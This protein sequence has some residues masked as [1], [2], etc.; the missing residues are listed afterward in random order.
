MKVFL[1]LWGDPKFY[2]TLIFLAQYLSKKGLKIFIISKNTK[3]DKNIIKKVDFGKNTKIIQSP[4]LFSGYSNIIDY[5]F[6]LFL[7]FLK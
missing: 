5:V 6:F 3:K 2:Q 4:K 1:V 7:Y